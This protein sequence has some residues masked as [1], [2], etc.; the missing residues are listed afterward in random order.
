MAD[1]IDVVSHVLELL[2]HGKRTTT[3]K[4]AVLIGLMDICLEQTDSQG[5]PPSMITTRQLAEKVL[6]LYWSQVADWD[7]VTLKQNKGAGRA[8]ILRQVEQLR[9]TAAGRIG[10]GAGPGRVRLA[11]PGPFESAVRTIEWTLIEMPLPKLQRVG[12]QDTGW[13]YRIG[14]DDKCHKPT[15][16]AV[17][18]YQCGQQS[19]FD[20]RILLQPAAATAFVRLHG[21]LRPFVEEQWAMDVAALNRLEQRH[22]RDFLFG[23][24]RTSLSAVAAPLLQLQR[25]QCFYCGGRVRR[26]QVDHFIPWARH[27][28]N[29]L[30]NLVVAHGSCNN[31]KSDFLAAVEH[32]RRWRRRGVELEEDLAAIAAD[33]TWNLGD[34]SALGAARAIY[35]RLPTSARLWTRDREFAVADRTAIADALA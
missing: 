22:L 16:K 20:N 9:T 24:S 32:L 28:H 26:G 33:L 15:R 31:H 7:G 6:E 27:S 19:D 35:L 21:L 11:I 10:V 23:T 34:R 5:W 17:T 3:Y 18:A 8:A 12:E 25:G 14:W 30:H 4:H 13:L 1:Q 2:Q 29:G